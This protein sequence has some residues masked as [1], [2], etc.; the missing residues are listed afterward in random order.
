MCSSSSSWDSGQ[1]ESE[2]GKSLAHMSRSTFSWSRTAERGPV[3]LEGEPDVVEEV[4]RGESRELRGLVPEAVPVVD[5]VHPVRVVRRPAGVGLDAHHLQVRVPVEDPREHKQ[6]DDVLAGAHHVEQGVDLRSAVPAVGRVGQDVE[7]ERQLHLHRR[8]PQPVVGRVV[9]V[10]LAGHAGHHHGLEPLRLDGR[11]LV[12]T[13]GGVLD[14][15][16][17]GAVQPGRR[18]RAVLDEPTVVRLHAGAAV[19]EVGVAAQRHAHGGE[20]HLGNHAVAVLV[21]QAI[22]RVPAGAV[23][24]REVAAAE[25][26]LAGLLTGGGDEAHGHRHGVQAGDDVEVATCRRARCAAPGPGTPGR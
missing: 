5:V 16:L 3:V 19:V 12:H 26:H 17:A 4:L 8:G 13:V 7:A 22:R 1:V 23:P 15:R 24:V 25:G 21:G 18:E 10:G 2:W 20:Q 11:Q 14:R 6:S 9:V